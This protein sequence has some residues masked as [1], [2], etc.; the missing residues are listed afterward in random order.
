MVTTLILILGGVLLSLRRDFAQEFNRRT[1][2][3]VSNFTLDV[4]E[5]FRGKSRYRTFMN[6]ESRH[7]VFL[8]SGLPICME[9]ACMGS[10]I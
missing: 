6:D 7:P 4:V 5:P 1:H 2:D 10:N 9:Y 8:V 3:F